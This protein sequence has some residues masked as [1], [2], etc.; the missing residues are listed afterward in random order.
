MAWQWQL[1]HHH[2]FITEGPVW[3]G[4]HLFYSEIYANPT[5]K[6]TNCTFAE[7]G[8]GVLYVTFSG[9]ELYRVAGTGLRGA[10]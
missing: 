3:D 10:V 6:P 7:A 4:R 1:V 9:G 8:R 5:D 2:E